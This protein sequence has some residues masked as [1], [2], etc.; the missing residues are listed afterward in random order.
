MK[1]N[2]LIEKLQKI[3]NEEGNID[4]SVSMNCYDSDD[5]IELEVCGSDTC[6]ILFIEGYNN[7]LA[8]ARDDD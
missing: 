4:V 8:R 7:F 5:E 6:K 3:K 2:E 1:I